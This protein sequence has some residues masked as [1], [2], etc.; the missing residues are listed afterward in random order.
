MDQSAPG[1]TQGPAAEDSAT[2]SLNKVNADLEEQNR[3]LCELWEQ[4]SAALSHLAH[5]LRTP[6]TSILGFSEILLSQEEL[7]DAQRN[8]CQRIQNSAHQ[9]Q[10]NLNRLAE[11]SRAEIPPAD[12]RPAD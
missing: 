3:K 8:F 2:A 4:R 1:I 5:E 12:K 7:T 6:L 10:N 9:L 11:L